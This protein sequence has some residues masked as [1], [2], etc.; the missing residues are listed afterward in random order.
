MNK[1][2]NVTTAYYF[3]GFIKE[4][5]NVYEDLEAYGYSLKFRTISKKGVKYTTCP[6]W[7]HIYEID[8]GKIKC[9]CDADIALQVM[10]N[11]KKYNKAILISSDG[12]FDNLVKKLLQMD[13]LELVLAPCREGCSYL[14]RKAAKGRIA[15]L[16]ELR[17]KLEKI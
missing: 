14:L 6:K 15:F 4:N 17:S 5:T 12:D 1:R 13:K 9:D 16:N 7:G 8:K 3:V 10:D 11:I 2:H